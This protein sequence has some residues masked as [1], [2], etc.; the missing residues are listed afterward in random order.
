MRKNSRFLVISIILGIMFL[1]VSSNAM[2]SNKEGT[3]EEKTDE[4]KTITKSN[5]NEGDV[6]VLKIGEKKENEIKDEK[7]REK[8]LK[9]LGYGDTKE[10]QLETKEWIESFGFDNEVVYKKM[11]TNKFKDLGKCLESLIEEQIKKFNDI[12]KD[13]ENIPFEY[14]EEPA[15]LDYYDNFYGEHDNCENFYVKEEKLEEVCKLMDERKISREIV[16]DYINNVLPFDK[17]TRLKIKN[18][19]ELIRK[20]Y[21]DYVE[22]FMDEESIQKEKKYKELLNEE[23]YKKYVKKPRFKVGSFIFKK[24]KEDKEGEKCYIY[25][26]DSIKML[27][28]EFE[29]MKRNEE[30][31]K[32]LTNSDSEESDDDVSEDER[33][34][35]RDNEDIEWAKAWIYMWGGSLENLYRKNKSVNIKDIK[36]H[37]KKAV[38]KDINIFNEAISR[39]KK[40]KIKFDDFYIKDI[41]V[42]YLFDF[43]ELEE[44]IE[45]ENKEL[46]KKYGISI[47]K[48][49]VSGYLD[50]VLHNR[51][52]KKK[53]KNYCH[54]IKQA[55]ENYIGFYSGY[56]KYENLNLNSYKSYDVNEL[57]HDIKK[58]N[59]K[60]AIIF[61]KSRKR[62][63][64]EIYKKGAVDKLKSEY[65]EME[66]ILKIRSILERM[67]KQDKD[68]LHL[69]IWSILNN[70]D[71]CSKL[72]I[73]D[74]K[75]IFEKRINTKDI[76]YFEFFLKYVKQ[77]LEEGKQNQLIKFLD[78]SIELTKEEY[79]HDRFIEKFR[80]LINYKCRIINDIE[81]INSSLEKI[82]ALPNE[83]EESS[84]LYI[85]SADKLVCKLCEYL[86][87]D[88]RLINEKKL[89]KSSNL[90]LFDH[91]YISAIIELSNL[92]KLTFFE[93]LNK[94]LKNFKNIEKARDIMLF[95]GYLEE[96]GEHKKISKKDINILID[97]EEIGE[98]KKTSEK[99]INTLIDKIGNNIE[100]KRIEELKSL[101]N[102]K[103]AN[104]YNVK[105]IKR[106]RESLEKFWES[107]LLKFNQI[108]FFEELE[109]S[110]KYIY[111]DKSFL[112]GMKEIISNLGR[113][114]KQKENSLNKDSEIE[115]I[116]KK[117]LKEILKRL[118]YVKIVKEIKKN[119]R[120]I[121]ENLRYFDFKQFIAEVSKINCSEVEKFINDFLVLIQK[122][123]DE[124][125]RD[126]EISTLETEIKE[127]VNSP[128]LDIQN[129]GAFKRTQGY[130]TLEQKCK[131]LYI[132]KNNID[133]IP[134]IDIN[135]SLKLN[136]QYGRNEVSITRIYR[137]NNNNLVYNNYYNYSNNY[138][139]PET[140]QG[141][142]M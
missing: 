135:I 60:E 65:E 90:K 62:E 35:N 82:L 137:N 91:F 14:V 128:G 22:D 67:K 103:E 84:L 24:N 55:Y 8:D 16:V 47:N 133:P 92:R 108:K 34:D 114:I 11:K 28:E 18:Y 37:L 80:K 110:I 48:E 125:K 75:D 119:I 130:K 51:K 86:R 85:M 71:M 94:L 121:F 89:A 136:G 52:I 120:Y 127:I 115:A 122:K 36:K 9:R 44:I 53:I 2:K 13:F 83:N 87:K 139:E 61:D 59:G 105:Y 64:V 99:D 95:L 98:H 109:K 20:A 118:E 101:F 102:F 19:K 58:L 104:S 27:K 131:R 74:L 76:D 123:S 72:K 138:N 112:D 33:I 107:W 140:R 40:Y 6:N 126:E 31:L 7:E 111:D 12:T 97:K 116:K 70:K 113:E 63:N 23:L 50:T 5:K 132:L 141:T 68:I 42:K 21:E 43:K 45:K 106:I 79:Y 25:N 1:G 54:L 88:F 129:F 100:K 15:E 30:D 142:E 134:S 124:M 17:E 78:K 38:I 96:I 57:E 10:D 32:V 81:Y 66:N 46:E 56:H 73:K 26:S 4:Y 93:K 3:R 49:I 117:W 29:I 77:T 39:F 41:D 69:E